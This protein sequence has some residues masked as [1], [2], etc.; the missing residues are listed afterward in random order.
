MIYCFGWSHILS[1]K[2]ISCSKYGVAGFHPASLPKN[3]GRHPI[4]WAL[5]LGLKDT[6]STFFFIDKNVDSGNIISQ[7]IINISD[8]DDAQTLYNKIINSSFIQIK[9]FTDELKKLWYNK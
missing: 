4:V 1:E 7:K 6:A 3:R 2:I 8:K 5:F 9:N